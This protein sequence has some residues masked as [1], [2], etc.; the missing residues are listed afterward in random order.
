VARP[1]IQLMAGPEIKRAMS[2]T[3]NVCASH[4]IPLHGIK[5]DLSSNFRSSH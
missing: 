5:V 1:P 3:M 4:R 2:T